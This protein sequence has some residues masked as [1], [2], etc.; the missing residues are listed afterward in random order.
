MGGRRRRGRAGEMAK[1]AVGFAEA[2]VDG[3]E[4]ERG[5]EEEEEEGEAGQGEGGE[6]ERF[7][8]Y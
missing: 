8:H 2:V 3:V 4:H 6:G 7:Y 5:G 1:E